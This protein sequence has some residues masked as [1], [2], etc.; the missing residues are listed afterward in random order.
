M[1]APRSQES[2]PRLGWGFAASAV[3]SHTGL[4]P[5]C[6]LVASGLW[7][8]ARRV[9]RKMPSPREQ[10]RCASPP[11]ASVCPGGRDQVLLVTEAAV[12][13]PQGLSALDS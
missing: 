3:L 12:V 8:A 1:G 7:A 5:N 11:S 2:S 10:V 9:V 4:D 13:G 6:R